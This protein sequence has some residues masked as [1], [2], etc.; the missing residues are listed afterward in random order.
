MFQSID[1]ATTAAAVNS[2]VGWINDKSGN[3]HHLQ[4]PTTGAR[5]IL[6]QS[7][8]LYYLEFDGTDDQLYDAGSNYDYDFIALH[9][10]NKQASLITG[11]R[12][13]N[14]QYYSPRGIIGTGQF[15]GTNHGW[16]QWHGDEYGVMKTGFNVNAATT[17]Y[18]ISYAMA[19]STD[20]VSSVYRS[21]GS[22]WPT[23]VPSVV[24]LTIN[25]TQ[26]AT[27]NFPNSGSN[28]NGRI[29]RVGCNGLQGDFM[30]GRWYGSIIWNREL[31]ATEKTNMQN[32]MK[33]KSGVA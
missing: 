29:L 22:E 23:S 20:F 18:Q 14:S 17:N 28:N 11:A 15:N 21:V 8:S 2:P 6:R 19:L 27:V 3:G 12:V 5:P 7:G 26:Q 30:G 16:L 31:N 33:A 1:S 13:T 4:A 32:W 9:G 25:S 10:T 24:K